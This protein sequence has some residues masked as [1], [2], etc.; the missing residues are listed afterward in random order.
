MQDNVV[1]DY[2]NGFVV[3]S[4]TGE[5]VDVIYIASQYDGLRGREL[6]DRVHY[7]TLHE[8]RFT[9]VD[10]VA[11]QIKQF[12]FSPTWRKTYTYLKL[13]N[14]NSRRNE[15]NLL[16]V[17][18]LSMNVLSRFIGVR[19]VGADLVERIVR[20]AHSI[21]PVAK[22]HVLAVATVYTVAKVFSIPIDVYDI[23]RELSLDLA[24]I[25]RAVR[26]AIK[27]SK[28][29]KCDKVEVISKLIDR[30]ADELKHP[31]LS[32]VAKILLNILLKKCTDIL[33]GK[34]SKTIAGS[35]LYLSSLLLNTGI[36]APAISSAV[37]CSGAVAR[38]TANK[39]A[40]KLGIKLHRSTAHI[41][42]SITIPQDLCRNLESTSV[43][44]A[45][46][47]ICR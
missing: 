12:K 4:S 39:I 31:Q 11:E 38:S 37:G 30:A 9:A 36:Y 23:G 35:L 43:K 42:I 17:Y 19:K 6:A 8:Y 29:Y 41:V 21:D 44:L 25:S 10:E 18:M 47:V 34:A 22:K 46:Y 40:E 28:K 13:Q 24:S 16:K 3:N 33:S 27:L 26:I 15:K 7:S 20:D 32:T 45:N 1:W 5:V 2:K 14:A